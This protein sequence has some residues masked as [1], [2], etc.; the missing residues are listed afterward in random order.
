[1]SLLKD[2]N[3]IVINSI[4]KIVFMNKKQ[5]LI[6][7]L[8][9]VVAFAIYSIF[10][11]IDCYHELNLIKTIGYIIGGGIYISLMVFILINIKKQFKS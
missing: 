4:I 9:V 2:L 8:L 3:Y 11:L 7:S 10:D 5:E 1:L 6:F